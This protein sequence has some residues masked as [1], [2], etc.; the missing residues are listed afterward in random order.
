MGASRTA[1]LI[2]GR[3][4]GSTPARS[5][6][7]LCGLSVSPQDAPVDP[8]RVAG[9]GLYEG[10]RVSD[11]APQAGRLADQTKHTEALTKAA[12]LLAE[13]IACLSKGASTDG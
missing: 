9:P 12:L 1:G 2:A 10:P 3:P 4:A 8:G 13:A 7:D 5:T 6:S 11:D